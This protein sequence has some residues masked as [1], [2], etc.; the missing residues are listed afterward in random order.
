MASDR[1]ADV[2]SNEPSQRYCLALRDALPEEQRKRFRKA[3]IEIFQTM[4]G[5]ICVAVRNQDGQKISL[6]DNL[7]DFPSQRLVI[8]LLLQ[9]RRA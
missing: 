1:D 5:E 2:V 3:Y 6:W 9:M 8:G 4:E 7:S